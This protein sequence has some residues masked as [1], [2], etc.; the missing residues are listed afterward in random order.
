MEERATAADVDVVLQLLADSAAYEHPQA[1]ARV[2]GRAAIGAAI[3]AFLGAT[4]KPRLEVLREIMAG[5]AVAAEERISFET[6]RDGM[7]VAVS[8]TQLTVYHV[9]QDRIVRELQFWVR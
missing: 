9:E 4:R 6:R 2:V 8:R 7:W 5:P 1:G 3:R